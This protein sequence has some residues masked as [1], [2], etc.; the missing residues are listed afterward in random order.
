MS[1]GGPERCRLL[2]KDACGC[3]RV[4][5][6][7]GFPKD[8]VSSGPGRRF[9]RTRRRSKLR[10]RLRSLHLNVRGR[11]VNSAGRGCWTASVRP[12]ALRWLAA[13]VIAS[14]REHESTSTPKGQ[15]PNSEPRSDCQL[16]QQN[17]HRFVGAWC[18]RLGDGRPANSVAVCLPLHADHGTRKC[19]G[20]RPRSSCRAE[21]QR[22]LMGHEERAEGPI[23]PLCFRTPGVNYSEQ[24]GQFGP[25]AAKRPKAHGLPFLG[26]ARLRRPGPASSA[27][28]V[29]WTVWW[30]RPATSVSRVQLPQGFGS[31]DAAS[32]A[33]RPRGP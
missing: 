25:S 5:L 23:W 9:R 18:H 7:P 19:P 11:Q 14:A 20:S 22:E 29:R 10:R 16:A 8:C 17:H 21:T 28:R 1:A 13:S 3:L 32:I 12:C 26:R 6:A 4:G 27:N 30:G 31:A 24:G 2:R 15:V 33:R